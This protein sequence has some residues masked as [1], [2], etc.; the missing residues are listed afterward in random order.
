VLRLY[1]ERY[2]LVTMA[3]HAH[4][5][6]EGSELAVRHT[7]SLPVEHAVTSIAEA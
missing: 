4:E 2:T 3:A 7:G 5:L 1:R 6:A